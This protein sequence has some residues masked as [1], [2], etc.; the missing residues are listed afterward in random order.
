MDPRSRNVKGQF[1]HGDPHPPASLV[2]DTEYSFRVGRNDH[3]H[4]PVGKRLENLVNP[5][6]VV[7][8]QEYPPR[9]PEDVAEPL[10]RKSD[11][12][13]IDERDHLLE[14]VQEKGMEKGLVPVLESAQIDIFFEIGRLGGEAFVSPR[15][16]VLEGGWGR[17][18]KT[19]KPESPSLIDRECG[20]LVQNGVMKDFE[21]GGI[22]L[23]NVFPLIVLDDPVTKHGLLLS[24]PVARFGVVRCTKGP[25]SGKGKG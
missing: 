15:H 18:E 11:G 14:M 6:D 22:D 10:A 24:K 19:V 25:R 20:S 9:I 2:P 13:G 5:V 17:G 3:L 16:L 8:G 1:S 23:V 4:I 12:R 7:R 21:T